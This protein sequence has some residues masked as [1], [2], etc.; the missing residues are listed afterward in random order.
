MTRFVTYCQKLV[1]PGFGP[2]LSFQDIMWSSG[3]AIFKAEDYVRIS[4]G[5]NYIYLGS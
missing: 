1:R 3:S 5:P 2:T 4:K